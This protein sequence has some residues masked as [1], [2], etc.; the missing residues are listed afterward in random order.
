MLRGLLNVWH[1]PE[2]RRVR[3]SEIL[4]VDIELKSK[5]GILRQEKLTLNDIIDVWFRL[6]T[7]V[8]K[9]DT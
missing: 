9:I 8:M 5:Q 2:W 4:N 3:L 6:V 1:Y 7:T